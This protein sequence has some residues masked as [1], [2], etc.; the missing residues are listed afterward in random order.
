MKPHG[1]TRRE[2]LALFGATSTLPL[3]RAAT[4]AVADIMLGSKTITTVSDGHLLLPL[5]FVFPDVPQDE[6]AALLKAAGLG[7]E[8]LEPECNVTVLRDGERVVLFD[9][10]S[11]P[12][13]MP[14][15]GK[16]LDN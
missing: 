2:A 13:F 9:V 16:I 4:P 6:L 10:G 1:L 15:A 3:L 14:S 12:N 7:T 8:A 11:G 5:D